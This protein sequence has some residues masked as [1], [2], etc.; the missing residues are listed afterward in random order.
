MVRVGIEARGT[1]A[2]SVG[3][4]FLTSAPREK[5]PLPIRQEGFT[6]TPS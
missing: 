3:D 6:L 1:P 5:T 4:A 2:E